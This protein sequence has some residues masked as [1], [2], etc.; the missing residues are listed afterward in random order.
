MA[1]INNYPFVWIFFL[2]AILFAFLSIVLKIKITKKIFVA[3]SSLFFAL[4]VIETI[5]SF[6][7]LPF[8]TTPVELHNKRNSYFP[9]KGYIY[10]VAEIALDNK[11]RGW[12]LIDENY[13]ET[14]NNF[15]KNNNIVIESIYTIDENG[16]R[17]TKSSR[18][19]EDAYL[20]LGCSFMF[21]ACVNDDETLP[22][23]FSK[24]FNF[25]KKVINAGQDGRGINRA[26]SILANKEYL[27][28]ILGKS[29]LKCVFYEY[30]KDHVGRAFRYNM[31]S[32]IMIYENGKEYEIE[33]PFKIVKKI[34]TKCLIYERCFYD[35]VEKKSYSFYINEYILF[36]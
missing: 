15:A 25:E 21:G 29:K 18:N 19:S 4:F 22:Y 9:Q 17:Y 3:L 10:K 32:D 16:L 2:F 33:Q 30:M 28:E 26:Y 5:L 31:P 12:F 6:Y 11:D 34:F 14:R 1:Y 24:E 7:I 35:I 13:N 36:W 23:L 27:K 8:V 20:F